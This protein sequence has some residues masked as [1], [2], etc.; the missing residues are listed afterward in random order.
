MNKKYFDN[1]YM[2]FFWIVVIIVSAF[3]FFNIKS[4]V[5][6]SI[7]VSSLSIIS[8]SLLILFIWCRKP[9][10]F[11]LPILP[12]YALLHIVFLAFPLINADNLS[13]AQY[14]HMNK[15]VAALTVTIF[16]L[17]AMIGWLISSSLK[18]RKPAQILMFTEYEGECIFLSVIILSI[19]IKWVIYSNFINL[20][21][22]YSI[23][24][25]L[26]SGIAILS[27]FVLVYRFGLGLLKNQILF[28]VLFFLFCVTDASN[29]LLISVT[30]LVIF[31]IIAYFLASKKIPWVALA[32]FL[33]II[34]TLHL[35]KREMRVRYWDNTDYKHSP[36]E[37]PKIYSEWF[38]SSV[39]AISENKSDNL[40]DESDKHSSVL[41]R[42]SL[43]HMLLL[44]QKDTPK[45]LPYLY[46]ATYS[47]ILPS[48]IPRIISTEKAR[49][50][51]G[52][53]YLSIYYG[54]LD[55][56]ASQS[57]SISWGM[58]TEAY[59]NFGLLGCISIGLILG[60][61][62]GWISARARGYPLMSFRLLYAVLVM[63]FS[64]SSIESVLSTAVTS[65]FHASI[66]LAILSLFIMKNRVIQN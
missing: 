2:K 5:P 3:I 23:F 48:L 7:L 10:K 59:V 31:S 24:L 25:F 66:G 33:I 36:L 30:S 53:H 28:F 17:F 32:I 61:F 64:I 6:K 40:I 34:P 55:Y 51:E 11:G 57:T 22:L 45:R 21:L 60:L 43:I 15:L 26:T 9:E 35:G 58:L 39:K 29:F 37:Y 19:V 63:F 4:G 20:G 12:I 46:G 1:G 16:L 14:A 27:I 62:F 13:I 52:T 18:I 44:A 8:I 54:L 56:E 50:T 65:I 41:E 38:N 49:G 47:Y 42:A